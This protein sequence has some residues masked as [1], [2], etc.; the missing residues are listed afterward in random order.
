M[1]FDLFVWF[2]VVFS[3]YHHHHTHGFHLLNNKYLNII[4]IKEQLILY[5]QTATFQSLAEVESIKTSSKE[6][7]AK[8]IS[9]RAK[10]SPPLETKERTNQLIST[11]WQVISL[12]HNTL[13][14]FT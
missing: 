3:L 14:I 5:V 6:T 11:A 12:S 8:R 1:P 2:F 4:Q 9:Q 13:H 10:A 7:T